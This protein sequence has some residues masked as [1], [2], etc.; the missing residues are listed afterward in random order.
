LNW[1]ECANAAK[2]DNKHIWLW[3]AVNHSGAVDEL[4]GEKE[5]EP[6]GSMSGHQY[7]YVDFSLS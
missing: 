6:E 3:D 1:P 4:R 5:K 7:E 2:V